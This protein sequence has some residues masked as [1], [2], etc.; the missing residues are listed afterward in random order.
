MISKII[1]LIGWHNWTWSLREAMQRN[2][3]YKI[4]GK[5]PSFAK[6]NRCGVSLKESKQIMSKKQA[7]KIILEYGKDNESRIRLILGL[8]ELKKKKVFRL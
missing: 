1:C 4:D 7:L 5:I 3:K 6:C 8:F 2:P